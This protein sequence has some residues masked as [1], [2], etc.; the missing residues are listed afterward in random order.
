M[1]EKIPGSALTCEA[2]LVP[3]RAAGAIETSALADTPS[4]RKC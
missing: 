3:D 2:L 4:G 1:P